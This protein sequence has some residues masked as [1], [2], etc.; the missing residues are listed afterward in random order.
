MP[1]VTPY[2]VAQARTVAHL[3]REGL[4][5]YQIATALGVSKPRVSQIRAQMRDLADY[6]GHPDP[7]DRLKVRRVQLHQ[8][9][10][11]T[12]RLA[13]AIRHDLRT[14][15]EELE[16]VEIDRLTGLRTTRVSGTGKH[17]RPNQPPDRRTRE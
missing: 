7:T 1:R 3:Q 13:M 2:L 15:D 10:G 8:L 4:S 9:R 16:A 14:L 17:E 11:D 12:L 6:L 5:T